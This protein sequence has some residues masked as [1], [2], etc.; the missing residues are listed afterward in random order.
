[1]CYGM[2][3]DPNRIRYFR[4][5]RKKTQKELARQLNISTSYL[6][7]LEN[8]KAKPNPKLEV[9]ISNI[10]GAPLDYMF[11]KFNKEEEEVV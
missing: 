2:R 9:D 11:N 4:K 1:M 7:Q 6:S 5:M 3:L 8:F 10:L